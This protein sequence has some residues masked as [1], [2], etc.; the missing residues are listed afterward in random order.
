MPL[1]SGWLVAT[2]SAIAAGWRCWLRS[3]EA[4]MLVYH[5]TFD[6]LARYCYFSKRLCTYNGANA[7]ILLSTAASVS[8]STSSSTPFD[9]IRN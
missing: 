4:S 7:L 6:A 5:Q 1:K 9:F 2:T 8:S 3:I